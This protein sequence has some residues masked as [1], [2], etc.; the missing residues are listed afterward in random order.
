M[1]L[2][3]I[4]RRG[5]AAGVKPGFFQRLQRFSGG[6]MD[7]PYFFQDSAVENMNFGGSIL[8]A[9]LIGLVTA[10]GAKRHSPQS[11]TL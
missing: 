4:C 7:L 3:D 5:G 6:Q 2:L 8:T 10:R 1:L 11:G 9:C